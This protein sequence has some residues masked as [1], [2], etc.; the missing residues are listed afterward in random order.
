M[1]F[2]VVYGVVMSGLRMLLVCPVPGISMI[3]RFG[4]IC[5]INAFA[6][7]L[8]SVQ[9]WVIKKCLWLMFSIYSVCWKMRRLVVD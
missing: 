5:V 8:F 1:L 2:C 4:V 3:F 6:L 9:F 7:S